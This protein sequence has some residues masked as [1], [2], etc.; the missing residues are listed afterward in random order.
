MENAHGTFNANGFGNPQLSGISMHIKQRLKIVFI[1]FAIIISIAGL[2]FLINYIESNTALGLKMITNTVNVNGLQTPPNAANSVFER[3]TGM[4]DVTVVIV[5]GETHNI[6]V[7]MITVGEIVSKYREDDYNAG[8]VEANVSANTVITPNMTIYINE[9]DYIEVVRPAE[10]PYPTLYYDVDSIPKGATV[11][12]KNGENTKTERTYRVKTE[13]G[14][15][16]SEEVIGE[17]EIKPGVPEEIRRGIGGTINGMEYS[18]CLNVTA[19]AYGVDVGHGG[20][21][22]LTFTGK[23]AGY[24]IIA[25]DPEVIKLGSK[26]YLEV[27]DIKGIFY[28]EDKG[29]AIVGN[30]IDIH[31]GGNLEKQIAFGKQTN[32]QIY[33][34]E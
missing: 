5:G 31:L 6:T 32:V 22:E 14:E 16:H 30:R 4:M 13:N 23:K 12:T 9:I 24:G 27:G 25:V 17:I 3:Y 1:I 34:L 29:L 26:V 18:Y 8:R 28:A 11:I 20:G 2:V 33:I 10:I 19:T 7:P 15:F 21:D